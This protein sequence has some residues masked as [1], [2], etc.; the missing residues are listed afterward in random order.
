M[1]QNKWTYSIIRPEKPP[2][3]PTQRS[4]LK[5]VRIL[6]LFSWDILHDPL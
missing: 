1:S 5:D 3:F 2:L 6:I 4:A